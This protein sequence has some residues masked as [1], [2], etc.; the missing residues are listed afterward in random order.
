M[1]DSE[2]SEIQDWLAPEM[3]CFDYAPVDPDVTTTPPA[4]PDGIL[5]APVIVTGRGGSGTRLLADIVSACGVFLGGD[6][7]R[8]SDSM[9]WVDLTYELAIKKLTPG[10]DLE[11]EREGRWQPMV[12]AQARYSLGKTGGE[13]PRLW[14]WKL[15]ETMIILPELLTIFGQAKFLH[16][17]RHPVTSSLR[18]D[19][20]TSR[21]DNLVGE[22]LLDAAYGEL[23]RD[24]AL[25]Y[26]DKDYLRNAIAWRFQV[27]SAVAFGRALP[28]GRYCEIRYE[29]LCD[30]PG[31]V[32]ERVAAFIG[33][34]TPSTGIPSIDATRM[35]EPDW[36]DPRV[37]E[38]W[39][40]CGNIA[41]DIGYQRG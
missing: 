29:D 26:S 7:N 38:I 18:R 12:E 37:E 41:R 14:G 9:E 28:K 17:V 4:I 36:N 8:S 2:I 16:L 22:K 20:V 30:D 31:A 21:T 25:I 27:A 33:V 11:A 32:A 13:T 15:P 39:N 6:V 40:I 23:G 19:H 10:F 1:R 5:R 3:R 24:R 34:E 35:A